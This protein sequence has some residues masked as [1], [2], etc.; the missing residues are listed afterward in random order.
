[1]NHKKLNLSFAVGWFVFTTILL[2]VPGKK[3]PKISW[4]HLIPQYDKII[5]I[6]L[7]G[8]LSFLCC[9]SSKL[10]FFWLIA[11]LCSVYGIIM[12]FVQDNWI[13][14]RSFD[15]WDIVADT[16]GSFVAVAVLHFIYRKEKV[17]NNT[18]NL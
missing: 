8:I 7:F 2:C 12:E 13:P 1:M 5:H 14:N 9:K 6:C 15:N 16:V 18:S 4:I 17:A 10:K 3:L 11:L